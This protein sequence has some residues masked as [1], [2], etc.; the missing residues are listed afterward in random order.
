[1]TML[2]ILI[3]ISILLLLVAML[4][5]NWAVKSEQYD[6][7]DSPASQI[8]FDDMDATNNRPKRGEKREQ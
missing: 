4:C 8:L 2:Y 6:D 3:P 7:L 1:M 5:F